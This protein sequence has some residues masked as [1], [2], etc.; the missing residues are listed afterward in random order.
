M[1]YICIRLFNLIYRFWTGV[2]DARDAPIEIAD[3]TKLMIFSI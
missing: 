3:Y 2:R 1:Y